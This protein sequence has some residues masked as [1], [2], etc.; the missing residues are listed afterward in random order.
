MDGDAAVSFLADA[1][2][3]G[4]WCFFREREALVWSEHGDRGIEAVGVE[5][6]ACDDGGAAAD[7]HGPA[8]ARVE[9]VR[10][11]YAV[12]GHP[13]FGV[14]GGGD[15]GVAEDDGAGV[16]RAGDVERGHVDGPAVS[17]RRRRGDDDVAAEG[18]EG[19]CQAV[20]F[21]DGDGFVG[22]VAFGEAAEVEGHAGR[23]EGGGA[24]GGVEME[25]TES[26]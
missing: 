21:E 14:A 2:D 19:A 10:V 18:G 17:I 9:D 12:R 3:G 15:G 24:R 7:G 1:Q 22:G 20:R 5:A 16:R 6:A 23:V 4:A 26:G 25:V 8:G 13:L 11:A